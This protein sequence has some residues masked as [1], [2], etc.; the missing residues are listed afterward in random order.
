MQSVGSALF[1][2][3]FVAVLVAGGLS[4]ACV[5]NE[6]PE[7]G[8]K[9]GSGSAQGG[10]SGAASGGSATSGSTSG[11]SP[12][13]GSGGAAGMPAA[14]VA[15]ASVAEASGTSPVITDFETMTSATGTYT[16]ESAA[17]LGGTYVYSDTTATEEP[18]TSALSLSPGHDESSTQALEAKIHNAT[19]G[20]GVGLWFACLDASA[21]TGV[22]FWARGSSPAG[23]VKLLLSV[24]A[25]E[26]ESKGGDC[27]DAGPCA[28][29]FT[30]LEL[31]DEW[32]E[33]TFKWADFTDGDAA[34]AAVPGS[35]DALCGIEFSLP[36]DN[37]SRDLELNVDDVAFTTE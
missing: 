12:A 20:G 8:G 34:G 19:W 6:D 24:N 27:P 2:S 36:N 35:G 32:T 7:D 4:V 13:A 10:S 31:T 23:K 17:L 37:T 22:T 30:E 21:Y 16:F 25:V 33:H 29:P 15:C 9:A 3:A 1:H 28:R 11:G 5:S 14:M 18:S 26:I